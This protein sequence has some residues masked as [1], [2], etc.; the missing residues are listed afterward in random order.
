MTNH[1]FRWGVIKIVIDVINA[2]LGYE[3]SINPTLQ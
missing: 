2:I 1:T 3:I